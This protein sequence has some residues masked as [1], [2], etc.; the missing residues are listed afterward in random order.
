MGRVVEMLFILNGAPQDEDRTRNGLRLAG[1]LVKRAKVP[2]R[3]FLMGEAIMVATRNDKVP[4]QSEGLAE[5]LDRVIRIGDWRVAVCGT[6]MDA[7]SITR[8]DLLEGCHRGT[9][10]ELAEWTLQADKVLVF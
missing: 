6:C 3:L 1:A 8:I 2:V 9:M 10:S 7:R 4:C 5:V